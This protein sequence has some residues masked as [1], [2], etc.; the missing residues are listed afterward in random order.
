M[1]VIECMLVMECVLCSETLPGRMSFQTQFMMIWDMIAK[2]IACRK[3][4]NLTYCIH[5]DDL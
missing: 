1:L 3:L 2:K 5:Q 4:D